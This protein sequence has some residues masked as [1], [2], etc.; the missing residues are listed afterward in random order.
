M[1]SATYVAADGLFARVYPLVDGQIAGRGEVLAALVALG[2]LVI[3]AVLLLVYATV[4]GRRE[5]FVADVAAPVGVDGGRRHVSRRRR[6][7]R[8]IG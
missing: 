8:I 2:L 6:R 3:G 5:Y 7:R 1:C 4:A